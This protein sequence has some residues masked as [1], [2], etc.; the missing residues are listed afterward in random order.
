MNQIPEIPRAQL[1]GADWAAAAGVFLL[2]FLST[3]PVV[4]PFVFIGNSRTALR[5]SNGIAIAMLF[6]IGCTFGRYAGRRPWPMGLAMV[7][8]GSVLVAITIA[9]GG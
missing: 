1:D 4:I 6:A 3:F 8:I 9:L 5:V 2:V 7:A